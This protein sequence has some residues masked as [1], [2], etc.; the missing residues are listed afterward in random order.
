MT[1]K[2]RNLRS[3]KGATP[4]QGGAL[5]SFAGGGGL[6]GKVDHVELYASN[7]SSTLWTCGGLGVCMG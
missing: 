5:F 6:F 1:D 7:H 4:K 3:I 2:K